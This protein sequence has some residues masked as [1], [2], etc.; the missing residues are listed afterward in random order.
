M[1]AVNVNPSAFFV[2]FQH[3]GKCVL[4]EISFYYF[5]SWT[6][7]FSVVL[8]WLHS[9]YLAS[10]LFFLPPSLS[11][12]PTSVFLLL[13]LF[14]LTYLTYLFCFFPLTPQYAFSPTCTHGMLFSL[15]RNSVLQLWLEMAP[16]CLILYP[17]SPSLSSENNT[18]LSYNSR[19]RA[20]T[21]K[22]VW[23]P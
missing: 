1:S 8:L 19:T 9:I 3:V 14:Y 13:L 11:L 12:S 10:M 23:K 5:W 21:H 2:L 16:M 18:V 7:L 4:F 20:H 22:D 15:F 6:F 17:L